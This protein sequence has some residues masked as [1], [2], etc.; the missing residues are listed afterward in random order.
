[1]TILDR[2]PNCTGREYC[3]N[4]PEVCQC[5]IEQPHIALPAIS[6]QCGHCEQDNILVPQDHKTPSEPNV[7]ELVAAGAAYCVRCRQPLCDGCG[8]KDEHKINQ[9]CVN[10][11]APVFRPVTDQLPLIFRWKKL[12]DHQTD[13]DE[14]QPTHELTCCNGMTAKLTRTKPRPPVYRGIIYN[15][16]G[17]AIKWLEI[18]CSLRD[19]K[20]TI[21]ERIE[22]FQ[23]EQQTPYT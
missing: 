17:E 19:S 12:P 10:K 5:P 16:Q 20:L 21:E 23:K 6:A 22:E 13:N 8:H 1:M 3:S 7:R 11:D 18:R 9:D 15:H 2:V 4:W 14:I